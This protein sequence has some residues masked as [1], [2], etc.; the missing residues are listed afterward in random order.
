MSMCGGSALPVFSSSRLPSRLCALRGRCSLVPTEVA[1]TERRT[2]PRGELDEAEAR[3]IDFLLPRFID[4]IGHCD[5]AQKAALVEHLREAGLDFGSGAAWSG[6]AE[7]DL[8]T[9]LQLPAGQPIDP[10]R[11]AQLA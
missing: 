5:D 3:K 6:E 9:R 1:T 7:R 2:A 8:R 4:A 11:L 10:T